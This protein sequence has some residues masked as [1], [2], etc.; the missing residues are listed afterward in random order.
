MPEN[1]MQIRTKVINLLS[2]Y[3]SEREVSSEDIKKDIETLK[4]IES[5]DYV[6][7][8]LLNEIKDKNKLY[9]NICA[10][11]LMQVAIQDNL[12]KNSLE[13]LNDKK[14]S[15][16]KKFFIISILKQRGVG[17]ALD[18]IDNYITSDEELL[19]NQIGDFIDNA[20]NNPEVQIDL[21]DFFEN[22]IEEERLCLIKSLIEETSNDKLAALLS[23]IAHCELNKNEAQ[24]ISKTLIDTKSLYST[25]GLEFLIKSDIKNNFFNELE[26]KK[27]IQTIKKNKFSQTC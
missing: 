6:V 4:N 14:I 10:L 27:I 2:K 20:F 3:R 22:V 16:T 9:N 17:I 18:D 8:L 13:V 15:D 1:K 7:K 11:F 25:Y 19:N 23:L 21:L 24:L 5:N 12:E 26:T